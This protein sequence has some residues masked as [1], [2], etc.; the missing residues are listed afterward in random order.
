[1]MMTQFKVG[2]RVK[3]NSALH[4][5]RIITR[6]RDGQFILGNEDGEE[7]GGAWASDLQLA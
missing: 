7:V 3:L 1:M 2:D 4:I 6:I 5:V